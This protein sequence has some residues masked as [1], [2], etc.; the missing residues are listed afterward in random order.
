MS[1]CGTSEEGDR[2][3]SKILRSLKE[4]VAVFPVGGA[5]S[6]SIAGSLEIRDAHA[7]DQK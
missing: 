1:L 3:L 7:L 5:L 6:G 2:T 4:A